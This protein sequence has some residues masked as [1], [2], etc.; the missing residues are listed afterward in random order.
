M[1]SKNPLVKE[2]L[3]SKLYLGREVF[4]YLAGYMGIVEYLETQNQML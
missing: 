4:D 1:N 2:T 3:C